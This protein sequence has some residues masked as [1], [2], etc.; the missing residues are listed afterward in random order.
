LSDDKIAN[1]DGSSESQMSSKLVRPI[2]IAL[3]L[4]LLLSISFLCQDMFVDHRSW[5]A[6]I[7]VK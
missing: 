6:I 3:K 5:L 7:S 4:L 2:G 1:A